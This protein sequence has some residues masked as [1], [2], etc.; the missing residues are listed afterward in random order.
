MISIFREK[1]KKTLENTIRENA[2]NYDKINENFLGV[3][4]LK[5]SWKICI[6]IDPIN[7]SKRIKY[8]GNLPIRSGDT[9][10]I[11]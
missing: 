11:L 2:E 3:E 10:S 1:K 6:G 9:K 7:L 8:D 4:G 5:N